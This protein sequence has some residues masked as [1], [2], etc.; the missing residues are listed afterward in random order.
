M[1]IEINPGTAAI[2]VAKFKQNGSEV[3]LRNVRS[4]SWRVSRP[5]NASGHLGMRGF[6]IHTLQICRAKSLQENT[7]AQREDE[8][9]KLAAGTDKK[10]YFSGE[11]T[12]APPDDESNIVQ[13]IRWDNGFISGISMSID[14]FSITENL[15]V[16]VTDLKV[17]DYTFKR[18]SQ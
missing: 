10:A 17:D 7:E 4:V 12:V 15:E 1:S 14:E 5:A 16:T 13:T 8:T 2:T 6:L 3:E 11:I 9:I 18:V